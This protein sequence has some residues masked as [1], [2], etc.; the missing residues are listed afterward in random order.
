M[1]IWY[2]NINVKAKKYLF[3]ENQWRSNVVTR[4]YDMKWNNGVINIEEEERSRNEINDILALM[5]MRNLFGEMTIEE[6]F[7]RISGGVAKKAKI[8]IS[9]KKK[10]EEK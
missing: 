8:G 3:N 4:K 6:I 7:W 10:R 2:E 9:V 5:K 1:Y